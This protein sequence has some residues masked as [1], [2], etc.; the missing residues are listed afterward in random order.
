[1]QTSSSLIRGSGLGTVL[2]GLMW[3]PYGIFEMLQPWG[4]D[5]AYRDDVG[6]ELITNNSLYRLYSLPGSLALL[7]TSLGLL[8]ALTLLRLRTRRLGTVA[9]ILIY[10]AV[11]LALVSLG[12]VIALFDPAFTAS[13]IFGTLALGVA[14]FLAGLAARREGRPSGW[15]VLLLL[16]GV[17]GVFL[18][19]LWPLVYAVQWLPEGG[20]AAI[21]ALF[22]LG[23]IA[24]GWTLLSRR[25]VAS[26]PSARDIQEGKGF[27][28][29]TDG[30]G[31]GSRTRGSAGKEVKSGTDL[32]VA[33]QTDGI[34]SQ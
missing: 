12:G 32:E 16:L 13:R 22:G 25:T 2:G 17:V 6:Y 34:S 7:L 8:G 23:W 26:V 9:L 1:M 19:P 14:A 4:T 29:G 31:V 3:V 28:I 15:V 33:H 30:T 27:V 18:F 21:I 20:G 24:L 10:V 11:V 5:T